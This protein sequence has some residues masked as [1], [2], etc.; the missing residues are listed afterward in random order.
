MMALF[1]IS[2]AVYLVWSAIHRPRVFVLQSYTTSYSW[3]R[4]VDKAIR[5]VLLGRPYD[6]KYHYM[7]TKKHSSEEF[8][9]VAGHLA[10]KQINEWKPDILITVDDNAQSLVA[11]CY[12]DP[13]KVDIN[14]IRT[15]KKPEVR[16]LFGRC[17]A[18]HPDIKVVFSGIGAQPE[19]YGFLGQKNVTG[20]T[21]RM[22]IPALKEAL[23]IIAGQMKKPH[24]RVT[25]PIDDSTSGVYN[26]D[27][28]NRLKAKIEPKGI[29]ISPKVIKTFPQWQEMV[30]QTNEEADLLLFSNYHTI[31][32]GTGSK[33]RVPPGDLI[34]WTEAN[35]RIPGLGAWGFYVADGGMLSVGVSPFEQGEIAARMA[36]EII[37][38]GTEPGQMEIK[39]TH[40]SIIFMRKP[41]MRYDGMEF[42][43]IYEA[44]ARASGNFHEC[45]NQKGDCSGKKR[46]PVRLCSPT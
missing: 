10:R 14:Q 27:S 29:S 28:L 4:D 25:A 16:A 43:R 20:I 19:D 26:R 35:S 12:I 34:K 7:D 21:E 8:K 9:R 46:E 11:I 5:K 22:D 44:F 31:K 23:L 3:T 18:D 37:E 41:L 17:H 15:A 32:C 13:A 36:V 1:F 40:Q 39:T 33:Q 2:L 42:P 45:D 6:V 24:F 30:A 38:K